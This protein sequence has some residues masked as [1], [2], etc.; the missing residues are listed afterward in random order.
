MKVYTAV[1]VSLMTNIAHGLPR[2]TQLSSR[3]I[4]FIQ[5]GSSALSNT[6]KRKSAYY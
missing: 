4:Y 2:A 5:T 1:G 6:N 3:A